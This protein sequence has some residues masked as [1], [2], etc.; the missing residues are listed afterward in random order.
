MDYLNSFHHNH[1]LLQIE[2]GIELFDCIHH[3]QEVAQ[4][5]SS[6]FP[7]DQEDPVVA[8]KSQQS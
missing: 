6:D 7:G 3:Q 8:N 1:I 5:I 4:M 2:D